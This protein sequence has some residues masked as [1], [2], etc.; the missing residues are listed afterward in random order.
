[1]GGAKHVAHM[2]ERKGVFWLGNTAFH[3]SS[4]SDTSATS[5]SQAPV[6]AVLSFPITGH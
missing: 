3:I 5:T 2:G 6:Q 1:M 4:L